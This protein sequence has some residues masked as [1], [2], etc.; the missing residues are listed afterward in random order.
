MTRPALLAVLLAALLAGC[1]TH[2]YKGK[3]YRR[4]EAALVAQQTDLEQEVAE[5][6]PVLKEQ[7][8]GGSAT[9]VLPT[10]GELRRILHPDVTEDPDGK[11]FYATS[12]VLN[13]EKALGDALGR[14]G[15]V[16]SVAHQ[17]VKVVGTAS[18]A[19]V[20]T[21]WLV[22]LTAE[23]GSRQ[24]KWL[25]GNRDGGA[26]TEIPF[27]AEDHAA[28]DRMDRFVAKAS[29]AGKASRT[30]AAARTDGVPEG[31]EALLLPPAGAPGCRCAFPRRPKLDSTNV[32]AGTTW[33]AS[34]EAGELTYRILAT[35]AKPPY[36]FDP[37]LE[38]SR[39]DELRDELQ[40]EQL[41]EINDPDGAR[42]K[43]VLFR[44]RN[45]T[46]EKLVAARILRTDHWL[47][48]A[49]VL[50]LRAR[51]LD[52]TLTGGPFKDR[53]TK[54]ARVFLDSLNAHD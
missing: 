40:L 14:S 43:W 39:R 30:A 44:V 50:G 42:A 10:E 29:K 45:T 33:R 28:K 31:W 3:S 32:P 27:N 47:P 51:V 20:T 36:V 13:E 11:T 1:T 17:S 52:Q 49:Y 9:V 41:E 53:L 15:L 8:L 18:F 34:V 23:P 2:T 35:Q 19:T 54:Y 26:M 21:D 46:P 22:V 5:V 4:P 12:L 37:G 25:I 7:Q 16:A 38:G 24:T 48:A 6:T